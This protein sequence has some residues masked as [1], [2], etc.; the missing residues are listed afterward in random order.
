VFVII[1]TQ[2][3]DLSDLVELDIVT[4]L[5]RGTGKCAVCCCI[6]VACLVASALVASA[7]AGLAACVCAGIKSSVS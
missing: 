1:M 4:Q 5:V 6:L 7:L 3:S 2:E